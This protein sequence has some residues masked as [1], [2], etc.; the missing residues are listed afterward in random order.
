V[1][2]LFHSAEKLVVAG[3][4]HN[5][6]DLLA[7]SLPW[8]NPNIWPTSQRHQPPHQ[9]PTAFQLPSSR[10]TR[11]RPSQVIVESGGGRMEE[12]DNSVGWPT[13]TTANCL[14]PLI[15]ALGIECHQEVVECGWL[16][17]IGDPFDFRI[18]NGI[19]IF[20][21]SMDLQYCV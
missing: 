16:M 12:E 5:C 1:V 11:P 4:P 9:G 19:V 20:S 15:Y 7:I 3:R 10:R 6:A 8:A 13:R 18:A 21:K 17:A 2:G 14:P